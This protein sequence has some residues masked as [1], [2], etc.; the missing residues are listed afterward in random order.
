MDNLEKSLAEEKI[1]RDYLAID[2]TRLANERTLLAFLRTTLYLLATAVAI[3]ELQSLQNLRFLA[4]FMIAG[5]VV[6]LIVGIVNFIR[7]KNKINRFYRD[8][9]PKSEHSNK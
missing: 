5:S 1:L 4:W 2:R 8:G 3:L 9:Q 6:F 7:M